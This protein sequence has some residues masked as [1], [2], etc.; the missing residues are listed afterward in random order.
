VTLML[1]HGY[2]QLPVVDSE[3]RLVGY[4]TS[5][6]ALNALN[7][8][9]ENLDGLQLKHVLLKKPPSFKQDIDL[10]DLFDEMNDSF[11][12][13]VDEDGRLVQVVTTNDMTAYFRQRA[14]DIILAENI[15]STLKEYVQ[16][17]FFSRSDGE[18]RLNEAIQGIT[19]PGLALKESFSKAVKLYLGKTRSQ[20]GRQIDENIVAKVFELNLGQRMSFSNAIRLYLMKTQQDG[21]GEVAEDVIA[22]AYERFAEVKREPATFDQL[23]LANYISLF[24]YKDNWGLLEGVFGLK[25]AAMMT[26]LDS[27]RST[28]NDLAHFREISPNQSRQLRDCYNLLVEHEDAIRVVFTAYSPSTLDIGPSIR[29]G[30]ELEAGIIVT[31]GDE[32]LPGESRYAALSIWLQ[33]QPS[34][35]DAVATTF[36]AIEEMIGSELPVSAYKNRSWWANDSLGHLQSKLWLDVGWRVSGLNMS[37]R[38]V[39]FSRIKD[40]QRAYIDFYNV[41]ADQLRKLPGFEQTAISPDGSNW[42]NVKYIGSGLSVLLFA[43]GRNNDLRVEVYIDSGDA[44]RNKRLFDALYADRDE[45][46]K[47]VGHELVWQ[48]LDMKRASKVAHVFKAHI[49]DNGEELRALAEKAAAAMA[50]LANVFDPRLNG[51]LRR[52]DV[53]LGPEAEEMLSAVRFGGPDRS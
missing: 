34:E 38:S 19:D 39:R 45:I 31:T 49:I 7:N 15:E 53:Y 13:I 40:R 44:S 21:N 10:L 5:N 12:C 18:Q 11:A 14:S 2:T 8:Y 26:L 36:S 50:I 35:K 51:L 4:V 25:K 29:E 28:R 52:M 22:E 27:V 47:E 20:P 46:E 23:T 1:K 3:N 37:E 33:E 30:S 43:F 9:R 6:S 42:Q 17:A 24:L 41:V 16:L 48:R 32:P